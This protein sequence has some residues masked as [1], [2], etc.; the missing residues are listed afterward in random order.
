MR[1][2]HKVVG[3]V[4]SYRKNGTI[5]SVVSEILAEAENKGAETEKIYLVDRHIEFCTNCRTCLQQP[6][7][8]RGKCIWQ[9][10]MDE[11]LQKIDKADSLVIGAPVNFGNINALTRK[12]LERC[13]CYGYWP[14][15][16]ATP[17]LRK[18][19]RTKKAILV[20]S[21]AAPA[22]MA[23]LLTGALGALKD[24]AKMLGAKPIGVIWVGLVEAKNTDL[25]LR[26]KRQ[27]KQMGEKLAVA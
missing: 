3:I 10:D 5:D 25:P 19:K 18:P 2:L 11:I 24:L 7:E 14:D 6:G 1:S 27:A 21:S 15:R 12:F 9:D 22:W 20:S 16:A 8:E 26:I 13:V 23:R 4:G 17:K